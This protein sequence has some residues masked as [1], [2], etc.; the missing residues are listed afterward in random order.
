MVAARLG[1]IADDFT[2]ASDLASQLVS[3][4]M[5]VV[6]TIGVPAT[7]LE[8]ECDAVVVS[9]KSRTVAPDEAV[10][11]SL[12][13]LEWLRGAG[14]ER[15]VFK[16]CSTFDS[17][18]DGN[19]GPVADALLD[20]LGEDFTLAVPSLPANRRTV[21]NG[22][23]FAGD[24][25]LNESGMQDH[26]LTPMRDAFLPRVLQPQTRRPVGLVS[27]HALAGGAAGVRRRIA[28]LRAKGVGIAVCDTLDHRDLVSIAEG[29]A[30]LRLLTGGS[31]LG[32]TL[33]ATFAGF[34]P[35][36]DAARLDRVGGRALV[37]AGSCSRATLAQI[38]HAKARIPAM[39]VE[40][41]ALFTEFDAHVDEL[42]AF[43]ASNA[44][45]APVLIHAGMA[46]EHLRE[47][48]TRYGTA[49]SGERVERAL[50]TVARRLVHEG[51]VRRVLVA[52]GETSGAVVEALGVTG[53][54][55]GPSI[56]PGVP[57]TQS[58]GTP[59]PL[60]LALKSGNFGGDDIMTRAF[61]IMP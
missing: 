21:Y 10:R 19:I 37:L 12:R 28:E 24:V 51:G 3:A 4:G 31:G 17:T 18:P 25:L 38:E 20:A 46:P 42:V 8:T 54:R 1:C 35:R 14:C 50:A 5:R 23:L 16:Y 30:D 6:Q 33:P 2:G 49:A 41:D 61:E 27:H 22:Y 53:L 15:F 39:P 43:A 9:L 13:A 45:E 40:V 48:Q 55:I 34:A 57:W 32:L 44:G 52:G 47:V 11:H 26:P 56:D 59:E 36:G 58:V 29:S 60:A 7:P